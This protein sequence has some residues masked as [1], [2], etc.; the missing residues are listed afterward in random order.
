MALIK[1]PNCEK[2]IS[3]KAFQCIH[4]GF[5][6]REEELVKNPPGKRKKGLILTLAILAFVLVA[7]SV[8]GIMVKRN[9]DEKKAEKER[10][11]YIADLQTAAKDML[12]G[13]YLADDLSRLIHG[14]WYNAVYK[15]S[16]EATDQYTQKGSWS[17]YDNETEYYDFNTAL[18]NLQADSG[19]QQRI[20]KLRQHQE[21]MQGMMKDLK[22]PPDEHKEAYDALKEFYAAYIDLAGCAL[23]PMGNLTSY[24]S[25]VDKA[26][27]DVSN[28]YKAMEMYW[29]D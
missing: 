26:V 9:M 14:V 4:C 2:E 29:E 20:S 23:N 5:Q 15:K 11:E 24:A 27:Q 19:F 3:E 1:C 12:T 18:Q 17:R 22:N 13:A 10:A 6:L 28:C 16:D 8:A 21:T 7:G 25:S